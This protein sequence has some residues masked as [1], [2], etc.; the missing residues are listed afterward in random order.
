MT[1]SRITSRINGKQNPEYY[2]EYYRKNKA[3]IT[4]IN[5]ARYIRVR[6]TPELLEIHRKKSTEYTR[7]W[8][9][10]HPEKV[11]KARRLQYNKRKVRAMKMVGKVKCSRCGCNELDF[12][13]FNHKNGGGCKEFRETKYMAMTDKLLTGKRKPDGLEILCRVCNALEFLER[14]NNKASKRFK[15]KWMS[16]LRGLRYSLVKK[17]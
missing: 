5:K 1:S 7:R 9:K 15:I 11:K 3:R 16:L 10:K 4:E 17:L 2:K 13:E 8:R 6:S 14:K 12:L